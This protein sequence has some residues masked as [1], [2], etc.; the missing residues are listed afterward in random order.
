VPVLTRAP[1]TLKIILVTPAPAGSRS[2]NRATAMR[3]AKMLRSL[4]HRVRV[5][6]TWDGVSCELL[7]ALHARRSYDSVRRFREA[8]PE[9][10]LVLALTGTDLYRDIV[11]SPDAQTSLRL[12]TRFIV[13]QEKGL[14]ALPPELRKRAY[15][16]HQSAREVRPR[17][18]LNSCFEVC[19]SGHLRVEK[20]PFRAA[21]ALAH[22]PVESRIRV[23][24]LGRAMSPEMEWEARAWM[25][26]EP[27]YQWRGEVSHGRALRLLGRTR[28]LVV[29]SL[30]EGGANVVSEALIAGV[31]VIASR[32]PG[33]VGMLGEDYPGY[34]QVE[35]EHELAV[36]LN[37]AEQDPAFYEA[38]HFFCSARKVLFEESR[39]R[40]SLRAA[41][42]G[43]P[44]G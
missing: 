33:N 38:L 13:L 44:I 6:P 9:R 16:V 35:D 22:L 20:D 14:E 37:R 3:W 1:Q 7:I 25:A 12:A 17:K 18:A 27:R 8:Y 10:P 42:E 15:V 41:I 28:L 26:R 4:G 43:A 30:M 21:A 39:E 36:L 2:G 19:V 5:Q 24:H 32:I 29:S 11:V 31:P 40:E 34:Y 23:T